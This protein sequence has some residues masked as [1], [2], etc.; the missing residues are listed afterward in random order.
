M[1]SILSHID[2]L[3]DILSSHSAFSNDIIKKVRHISLLKSSLFS[4]KI[5]GNITRFEDLDT[6]TLKKNQDIINLMQ[7]LRYSEK[8]VHRNY[9]INEHFLYQLHSY[10]LTGHGYKTKSYRREV[11]AIYNAQGEAIYITP[12]PEQ[13]S[14]LMDKLFSYIQ[15][16]KDHPLIT[17]CISH[18][19]F[20]KVHPFIDGNGRVGRI[21]ISSVLQRVGYIK[22]IIPFEEYLDNHKQEYY[23]TLEYGLSQT[24]EYLTFMIRGYEEQII[25]L[26]ELIQVEKVKLIKLKRVLPPRQEEL[27]LLIKDHRRVS[28]DFVKRRFLKVPSRT[29]RYDLQKLC[30][31]GLINTIGQTRGRYYVYVYDASLDFSPDRLGSK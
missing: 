29:L 17:A 9:R 3:T 1:S 5:E 4:A 31:K 14:V 6:D 27:F 24:N 19:I 8:T 12:P 28:F 15:D 23:K 25:R 16:A 20:E 10:V 7:A 13:V 22:W 2:R 18:I 11:G 21:L 30:K 26:Q